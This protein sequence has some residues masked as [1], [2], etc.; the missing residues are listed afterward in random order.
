MK[1][2]LSNRFLLLSLRLILGFVFVYAGA[3]K[4]ITPVLFAESIG[5]YQLLSP[6]FINI[7][8]VL[9]PWLEIFSGI[10]LLSGAAVKE[11]SLILT[12][13]MFVFI[14]AGIVSLLRGLDIDCGCFGTES[15]KLGMTKILENVLFFAAGVILIIFG[16]DF[17]SVEK[18]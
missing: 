1:M 2:I 3:E 4:I 11:N 16:S 5:N 18:R 17:L 15:V 7:T 9:L 13:L 12:S 14:V 6:F 10:L 8:A